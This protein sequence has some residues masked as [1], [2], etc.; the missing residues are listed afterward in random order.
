MTTNGNIPAAEPPTGGGAFVTIDEKKLGREGLKLIGGI[1][2]LMGAIG[3]LASI[4]EKSGDVQER[5]FLAEICKLLMQGVQQHK[6][7]L[8]ALAMKRGAGKLHEIP[9]DAKAN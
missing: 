5:V 7:K 8:G 1:D 3:I 2:A 6:D 4:R 9:E